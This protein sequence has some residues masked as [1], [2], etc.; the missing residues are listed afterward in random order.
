MNRNH[1]IDIL[2]GFAI[3]S[4]ILLHLD[5]HL[6][7]THHLFPWLFNVIF[8]SGYYGVIIFFVISGFLITESILKKWGALPTVHLR[9]FYQMRFARI[10]PCLLALVLLLSI[11]D[12]THVSGFVLKHT[13]L[14][15][16]IFAALTFHIN[17][18]QGQT[19]YLPGS[20]D[21]LW[22]LSVE[23]VFYFIFPLL[24]FSIK[25]RQGFILIL[26]L[27]III[28][29][30]ARTWGNN[31]IWQDHGYLSCMDG[32]AF[33]VLA[34]LFVADKPP[35]LIKLFLFAGLGLFGLIFFSDT[36][37]FY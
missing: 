18:L 27:L 8:K 14:L 4:V 30:F 26:L 24:C 15:R 13:S 22:S 9:G 19:G 25:N 1:Y 6:P 28:G 20:W 23:E 32:I 37:S 31:E 3:L 2:R 35:R 36:L 29:P 21:M 5:I 34:A 33:G 12:L 17:W 16:T 10:M 11:L 7:F